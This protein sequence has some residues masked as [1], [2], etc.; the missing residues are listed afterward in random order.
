LANIRDSVKEK[1]DEIHRLD[2]LRKKSVQEINNE[3]IRFNNIIENSIYDYYD[4]EIIRSI[5]KVLLN[6][7]EN[8]VSLTE[9]ASRMRMWRGD[10]Q[11]RLNFLVEQIDFVKSER[12]NRGEVWYSI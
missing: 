1:A 2:Q 10:L 12:D 8:K 6:K 4:R 5:F 11:N 7:P 3:F 9:L